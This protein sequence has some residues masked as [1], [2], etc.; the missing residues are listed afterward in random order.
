MKQQQNQIKNK[1]EIMKKNKIIEEKKKALVN[2]R[3]QE[4]KR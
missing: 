1:T 3:P 2:W 4:D